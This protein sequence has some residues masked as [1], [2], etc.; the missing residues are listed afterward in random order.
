MCNAHN[1][2]AGCQCGFGPPYPTVGVTIRKLFKS[3]IN[4]SSKVAELDVSFPI[5]NT[6]LFHLI[7]QAGKKRLLATIEKALQQVADSRFGKGNI[8][9]TSADVK[10]GSIEVCVIL[11]TGAL[12]CLKNYKAIRDSVDLLISDMKLMSRKLNLAV[13]RKYK[14]EE[15]RALLREKAKK[16]EE[17][18]KKS[19][20]VEPNILDELTK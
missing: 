9:V 14:R 20:N 4:R 11:V 18:Q 5:S 2:P 8:K 1:H 12:Y 13:K 10:Q 6:R 15:L 17:Q 19:K 3:G 7:D 16:E